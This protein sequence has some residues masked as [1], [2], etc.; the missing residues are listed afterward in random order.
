[1]EWGAIISIHIRS[2]LADLV[3]MGSFIPINHGCGVLQPLS[4]KVLYFCFID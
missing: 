1:M 3:G 4:F 2:F